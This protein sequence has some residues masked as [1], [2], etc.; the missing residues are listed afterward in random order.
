MI[1]DEKFLNEIGF[2]TVRPKY[3]CM[4]TKKA[5]FDIRYIFREENQSYDLP[6]S[7]LFNISRAISGASIGTC[8]VSAIKLSTAL[9]D[10]SG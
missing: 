7:H 3:T 5:G 8:H 2:V 4:T 6:A 9:S 1:F 10:I